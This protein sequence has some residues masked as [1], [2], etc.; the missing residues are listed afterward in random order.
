M[1]DVRI[2]IEKNSFKGWIQD[3]KSELTGKEKTIQHIIC[4]GED[5][6]LIL[7]FD[8]VEEWQKAI[9][10]FNI[11]DITDCRETPTNNE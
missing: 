10:L 4:E 6:R 9:D 7:D 3:H 11:T 2:N 8:C 1:I 5:S